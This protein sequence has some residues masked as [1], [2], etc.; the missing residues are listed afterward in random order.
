MA[1]ALAGGGADVARA[2]PEPARAELIDALRQGMHEPGGALA[3][4]AAPYASG[5][6]N[7]QTDWSALRAELRETI[8]KVS[9][10]ME[11]T[12]GG[13][14]SGGH[15]RAENVGG[16]VEQVMRATGKGSRIENSSQTVI[17][18]AGSASKSNVPIGTPL[19][20]REQHQ[21][22]LNDH[23]RRLQELESRAAREGIHV[24]PEVAVEIADIRA[25]VARLK[26]LLGE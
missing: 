2:I 13:V 4:I 10:T 3:A 18:G 21:R 25:E 11:A 14:I 8:R 6:A 22:L 15:I 26:E 5:L 17:G 1:E 20:E 24:P 12:E 23:T 7:P 19:S 9:Q 16:N